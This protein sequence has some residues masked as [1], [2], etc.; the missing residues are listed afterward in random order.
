MPKLCVRNFTISMDGF[1]AGAHQSL[2]NPFGVG[3]GKLHDWAFATRSARAAIGMEGG[4]EGID[5]DFAAAG[6]AGIGATIMG[7]NMFGPIRGP[8]QD[9]SWTGWWGEN[10]PYHHDTFVMTHHP[11]PSVK[12][13]GG[14]TFHFVDD[15]P[16]AVLRRAFEAAAGRD[17]R[18]GGGVRTIHQFLKDRLVDELDIV[19]VPILLGAGERL[20]DGMG[21]LE[22]YTYSTLVA[23]SAVMH[24]RFIRTSV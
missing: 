12:M 7:R 8:W 10:P 13:A 2:D 11:R 14:T 17:V 20:F 6:D 3:G 19:I 21:T 18:L 16:Q 22:G 9:E 1:A 24:A 15:T 4:E 23:S 5:N